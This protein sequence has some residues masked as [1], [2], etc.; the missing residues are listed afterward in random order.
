MSTVEHV[1]LTCP[2]CHTETRHDVVYAGRLVV[3]VTCTECGESLERD[4]RSLYLADLRQRVATKPKRML[5]RFRKHPLR[6]ARSLP[7]TVPAKPLELIS[8]IR[9][10][11]RVARNRVRRR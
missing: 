7:K 4:I 10:V 3:A 11:W 6:F 2:R 1:A 8:E 9:L 5:R